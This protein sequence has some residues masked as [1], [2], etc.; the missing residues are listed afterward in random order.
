MEILVPS[1]YFGNIFYYQLVKKADVIYVEL[2]EH[3]EKQTFRNRCEI[4]GA[5][6][7]LNLIVPIKHTSNGR[8]TVGE[9]EINNNENWQKIHWRSFESAYRTSPYFEYY[10]NEFKSIFEKK[11]SLLS[12]LNKTVNE[13]M[14]QLLKIEKT[15]IPTTEYQK[16]SIQ[17]DYRLTFDPKIPV[18]NEF[19]DQEYVQVFGNKHGFLSNLSIVDLLCNCGPESLSYI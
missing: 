12:D 11:Y 2:Y 18:S 10:E 9:A 17:K 4:Y 3:F 14:L 13:K 16:N 6:G 1:V 8:K 5:N 19:V 15:F 7:R